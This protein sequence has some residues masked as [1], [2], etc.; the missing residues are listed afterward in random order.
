MFRNSIRNN[1]KLWLLIGDFMVL[2]VFMVITL[3]L[4]PVI[5]IVVGR[6]YRD[7]AS[8]G[9][10]HFIGYRTTMSM[11]ND[12]TW[13]FAHNYF[14]KMWYK[15][16]LVMIPFSVL[17]MIWVIGKDEDTIG[18]LGAIICSLQIVPILVSIVLTE[19]ALKDNFDKDGNRKN[20]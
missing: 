18:N 9:I 19:K 8:G 10:N 15:W 7:K 2:W 1:R 12:E 14:S 16:G 20:K 3:L 17:P 5:M 4:I 11:K 6:I 13:K